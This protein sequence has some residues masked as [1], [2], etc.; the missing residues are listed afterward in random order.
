MELFKCEKLNQTL[1]FIPFCSPGIRNLITSLKHHLSNFNFIDYILKLKALFGYNYIHRN[2]FP[3]QQVGQKVY[4]FKMFVNGAMFR[5]DLVQQMQP[6]DDLQNVL[7]MFDHVKH[8]QGWTTMAQHIYN[9]VYYK[10]MRIVVYDM[11][12]EDI[13]FQC[14]LWRKLNIVVEKKGLGMHVF[15]G[16]MADGAQANWNDVCIV[17]GTKDPMVKM[18][19]K[20]RTCFFHWTQSLDKH[21]KQVIAPKFHDR[22]KSPLLGVPKNDVLGGS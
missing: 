3:G 10:V 15:K 4:L 19:D 13:E 6:S 18:V 1:K 16:F 8:V 7:M 21:T 17:N 11:Q 14:I 9:F 2:Y 22:H 12:F 20:K 5:F